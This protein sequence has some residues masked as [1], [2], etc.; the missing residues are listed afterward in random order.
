MKLN[1]SRVR[2]DDG[3]VASVDAKPSGTHSPFP[4]FGI[5]HHL[6]FLLRWWRLPGLANCWHLFPRGHLGNGRSDRVGQLRLLG[7]V[8]SWWELNLDTH[9]HI[10]TIRQAAHSSRCYI[11]LHE[12]V[13]NYKDPKLPLNTHWH[14][15]DG[16]HTHTQA[17]HNSIVCELMS[18]RSVTSTTHCHY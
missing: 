14:L 11:S 4:E 1:I 17:V 10:H 15:S 18:Q 12:S 6:S 13:R 9:T 16:L 7:C 5:H 3:T 2:K 8:D